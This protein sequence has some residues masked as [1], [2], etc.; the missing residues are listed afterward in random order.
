AHVALLRFDAENARWPHLL[1]HMLAGHGRLEEA[2]PLWRRSTELAP[3]YVP[4]HLRLGDALTKLNQ[5]EEARASYLAALEREPGNPYALLGLA[6]VEL[7]TDRLT[8]AR[9]R[10]QQAV[11]AQPD[12]GAAWHLLATVYQRLGNA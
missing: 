10:L 7:Q 11:A 5:P 9:E 6:R 8:A 12:F 3:D 2:V 4:A 1:A